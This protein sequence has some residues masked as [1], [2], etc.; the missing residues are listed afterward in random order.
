MLIQKMA[1]V[2]VPH[3]PALSWCEVHAHSASTAEL[4]LP[5]VFHLPQP[6]RALSPIREGT[7]QRTQHLPLA[8]IG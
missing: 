1:P 5:P 8:M 3:T 7:P 4:E 2:L 6:Q